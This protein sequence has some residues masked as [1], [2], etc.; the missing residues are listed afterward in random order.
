MLWLLLVLVLQGSGAWPLVQLFLLE[1]QSHGKWFG[2]IFFVSFL[3]YCAF[4]EF[5]YLK[6][7]MK[8]VHSLRVE[9]F[10]VYA[11]L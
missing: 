5:I 1:A 3:C 11:Q 6:K 10:L 7:Y 8:L 2:W 4:I 9:L